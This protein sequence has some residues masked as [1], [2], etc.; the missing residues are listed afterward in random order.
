MSKKK[1]NLPDELGDVMINI[2]KDWSEKDQDEYFELGEVS[3]VKEMM[4]A[5]KS[6]P[7]LGVDEI[8]NIYI[9]LG[10]NDKGK[11]AEFLVTGN[12]EL[13]EKSANLVL[14]EMQQIENFVDISLPGC[15]YRAIFKLNAMWVSRKRSG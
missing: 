11:F 5:R 6:R 1:V 4:E 10:T 3:G 12:V 13:I 7:D 2:V 15:K 9:I 14:K 8:S